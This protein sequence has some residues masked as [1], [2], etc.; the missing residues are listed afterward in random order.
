MAEVSSH[1]HPSRAQLPTFVQMKRTTLSH[2]SNDKVF[3]YRRPND[4]EGAGIGKL[5]W[6]RTLWHT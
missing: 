1:E 3:G 5:L 4:S 6:T 2:V